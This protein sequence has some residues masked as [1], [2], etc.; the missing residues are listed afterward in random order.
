M[1]S[2][3][4]TCGT[5]FSREGE[6]K[7][8][9]RVRG[10][11]RVQLFSSWSRPLCLIVS[12]MAANFPKAVCSEWYSGAAWMLVCLS[13]CIPQQ[14]CCLG[15]AYIVSINQ[16]ILPYINAFI[17]PYIHASTHTSM[18]RWIYPYV[19]ASMDSSMHS[20]IHQCI[21]LS[22]HA[23]IHTPIHAFFHTSMHAYTRPPFRQCRAERES[24]I[25]L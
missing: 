19:H 13:T 25:E 21:H 7:S 6:K 12:F 3:I 8:C 18:H 20:S 22:T 16:C 2:P 17:H 9:L 1:C 11:S 24:A 15:P 23:F 14:R 4:E 5:W 10:V